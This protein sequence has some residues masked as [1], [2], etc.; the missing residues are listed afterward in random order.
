MAS[1]RGNK[2]TTGKSSRELTVSLGDVEARVLVPEGDYAVE[3]KE[4]NMKTGSDSGENY[5]EWKLG[6][7]EEGD[8]KGQTVYHNTSLQPQALFNLKNLLVSAG[9]KVPKSAMKL[10]LDEMEGLT[11]GVSIAH[12]LYDGKKK[13]RVVDIFPLQDEEEDGKSDG[14]EEEVDLESMGLKGL[15]AYAEENDIDL[16]DLSAKDKKNEKKVREAIEAALE[17]EDEDGEEEGEEEEIDFDSMDLDELLEFAKDN[18]I[19]LTAK[20]KKTAS[21][22]RKAIMAAVEEE[23]DEE[24]DI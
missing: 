9:V 14:E 15:L 19:K 21:R 17:E 18:K 22:A 11:F 12:E 8:L 16:S 3:V 6:I 23:G 2:G 10:N 13:A 5:L 1:R 7:A 24:E 4:V 20:E